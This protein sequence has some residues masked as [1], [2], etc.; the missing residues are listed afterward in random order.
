MADEPFVPL[1]FPPWLTWNVRGTPDLPQEKGSDGKFL[2]H[3]RW[4][5]NPVPRGRQSWCSGACDA[6]W[7][8]VWSWGA[9]SQYVRERDRVCQR[10]ST[11]HPGWMPRRHGYYGVYVSAAGEVYRNPAYAFRA[12]HGGAYNAPACELREW[13]EVDHI[14]EVINGGTDDP[15]NLRLLCHACHVASGV[16]RRREAKRGAA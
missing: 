3:C 15:A 10:C 5:R 4:C 6:K 9:I 1:D 11:E 14:R 13:W 12:E 8:R 16:E 2:P 7:K